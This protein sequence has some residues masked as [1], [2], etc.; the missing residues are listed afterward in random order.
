MPDKEN[1]E[2]Q[3]NSSAD[4][5]DRKRSRSPILSLTSS[6]SVYEGSHGS[7]IRIPPA[8]KRHCPEEK[9]L[10]TSSTRSSVAAPQT[11]ARSLPQPENQSEPGIVES[12]LSQLFTHFNQRRTEREGQLLLWEKNGIPFFHI[13]IPHVLVRK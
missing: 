9:P 5:V 10:D 6:S 1:S 8:S 4:N 13:F 2:T 7:D 12:V 3:D 11:L